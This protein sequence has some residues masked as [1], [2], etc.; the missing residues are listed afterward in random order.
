MDAARRREASPV[1]LTPMGPRDPRWVDKPEFAWT[2]EP[3]I[4]GKNPPAD[5]NQTLR[6]TSLVP[7]LA[8]GLAQGLV[9]LVLLRGHAHGW[10]PDSGAIAGLILA[11][12]F[13]PLLL[14]DGLGR[15]P[16]RALLLWTAMAAFW[17]W[18][19][20]TYQHWRTEGVD[21]GRSGVWLVAMIAALLFIGQALLLGHW[22]RVF[23]PFRYAALYEESWN[24]AI[25]LG[26][27][28]FATALLP[29]GR[30][31]SHP[32]YA[33]LPLTLTLAVGARLP[34]P[35]LLGRI[36]R[37][38]SLVLIVALPAL[39]ILSILT[40]LT[41]L[42]RSWRP[43]FALCALEALLLLIAINASYRGGDE[44]RPRWR[45]ALEFGAAFLLLPLAGFCATALQVRVAQFGF[46]EHRVMALAALLLL[47]AYALAYA[48]AALISLGGG[49]W[50]ARLESANLLMAFV[51]ASL[52]ATMASPLADPV[53]L[54]V[55]NQSWRLS[56]N[57]ASSRTF[58]YT[59]LRKW[60]LRYGHDALKAMV[61]GIT[62][63]PPLRRLAQP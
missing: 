32:A 22:R 5:F 6:A 26:F 49:R 36:R 42:L 17:L 54:S 27:A 56:H 11:A 59:Y 34:G 43:P 9:L 12:V 19:A 37:G 2:P 13:A 25:K 61:P 48:G 38:L 41:W 31:G 40:V 51:A 53:R 16:L 4:A 47:S 20:G 14:V 33:I 44:W 1:I 30:E 29:L 3:P 35:L 63:I 21:P 39:I 46:T 58:D 24:L 7:R 52:F 23:G 15:V 50:M 28:S 62:A 8:I 45:R 60:G 10:W 18:G 55:A 57:E